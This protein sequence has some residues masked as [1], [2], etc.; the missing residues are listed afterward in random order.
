MELRHLIKSGRSMIPI[1]DKKQALIPWMR[2][3]KYFP[4][5]WEITRWKSELDP[6]K[7]AMVT[8]YLSRVVTLDFDGEL[9]E[10]L[11]RRYGFRAHRRTPRGFHV[12]VE[13][14]GN[15]FATGLVEP[16]LDVRGDNGYVVVLGS[17]YSWLP[18]YRVRKTIPTELR[19]KMKNLELPF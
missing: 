19:T 7:W 18:D 2:Y 10:R 17:G 15:E 1:G 5:S 4:T 11:I 13:W 9:G 12:D 3:G 6:P 8:G 16:G 14:K